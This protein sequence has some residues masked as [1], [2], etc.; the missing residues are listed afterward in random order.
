MICIYIYNVG[1]DWILTG[2]LWGSGQVC[3]AT[4]RVLVHKNI[5]GALMDRLLERLRQVKMG[6]SLTDEMLAHEGPCMGP[7][8]N[9]SQYDKVWGYINDAK[10]SGLVP[11]YG[12]SKETLGDLASSPGY[13]IPP[14]VFVDVPMDNTIWREEIFGPVLCV[15][16]FQTEEEAVKVANDS[17]YGLAGAVMSNDMER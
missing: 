7:V 3:S 1:V 9:K 4:S 13:F 2:I 17:Q 12:G 8:V 11:I 16:E 5:R 6:G 10:A 15:R 14:T